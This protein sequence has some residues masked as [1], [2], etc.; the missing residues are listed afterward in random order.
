MEFIMEIKTGIYY[1]PATEG[2]ISS[3]LDYISLETTTILN[4]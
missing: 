4:F 2:C 3:F 1:Y